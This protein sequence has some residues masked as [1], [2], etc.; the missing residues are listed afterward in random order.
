MGVDAGALGLMALARTSGADFSRVVTIGRHRVN[1]SNDELETFFRQRNRPDLAARASDGSLQGYCE[2]LLKSIFGAGIVQSIDASDY[3][4]ADIVHDMNTP[5]LTSEAFSLVLDFGTLEHVFNVPVAFDNVAKLCTPGAH[6]LH[7][8]PSNN[9]VGHGFYQFSP[10]L[11][12][13]IYSPE[14]G[15]AGTRVF[16]SP[17]STPDLWY[18]VRAPRDVGARVDI[19]SRDQLQLLVLT[20]K[21]GDPIPLVERPVQQSDY[22][23]MWKEPR[24][25]AKQQRR[26]PIERFVRTAFSTL[27]HRRKMARRD[28]SSRRADIIPHRVLALTGTF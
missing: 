20:Q 11:F 21:V 10:E 5:I 18:E 2:Q 15:F 3:E 4:Q 9:F 26:S 19:S 13:Q 16:A 25:I 17:A 23:V 8:L 27:R 22:V 6:I 12:Y 7:V 1:V 14:R 28:V 24:A